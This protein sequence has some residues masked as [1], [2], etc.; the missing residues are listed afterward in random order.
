VQGEENNWPWRKRI[1]RPQYCDFAVSSA[2]QNKIL[3]LKHPAA[4]WLPGFK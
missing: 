2:R 4:C 1:N 3:Q